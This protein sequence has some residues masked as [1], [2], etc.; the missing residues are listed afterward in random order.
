MCSVVSGVFVKYQEPR[1]NTAGNGSRGRS[2]HGASLVAEDITCHGQSF[3]KSS[4]PSEAELAN[5]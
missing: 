3:P 5:G 4:A 2:F 1:G